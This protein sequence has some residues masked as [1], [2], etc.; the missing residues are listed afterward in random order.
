MPDTT[1]II[2]GAYVAAYGVVMG[3]LPPQPYGRRITQII[4]TGPARSTF[5]LYRGQIPTPSMQIS[6]T[7]TGGGGDNTY[8]STTDGAPGSIGPSEQVIGVWSGG[9]AGAGNT[10]TAIVKS[11]YA[12]G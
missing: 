5:K 7:P 10:G 12:V 8:D 1:D 3:Q 6:S 4:L 9:S 2:Q 11:T